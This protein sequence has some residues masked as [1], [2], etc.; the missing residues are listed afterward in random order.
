MMRDLKNIE[1]SKFA[2]KREKIQ[3][4]GKDRD[5]VRVFS[6]CGTIALSVSVIMLLS[7]VVWGAPRLKERVFDSR[8]FKLGGID[9]IGVVKADRNEVR[10]AIGVRAGSSVLETDLGAIRDR[11]EDVGWVKDVEVM[12]ELPSKLIVRVV[13]HDPVG[14]IVKED[15]PLFVDS[16][17]ETA[18][19]ETDYS[20]Y[21]RFVG[22]STSDEITSGAGLLG[23]IMESGIMRIGSVKSLEYDSVMGYTV[24]SRGG[25]ELR[26]GHPPFE[27]KVERLAIILLDATARG[28]IEYIYLDIEDRIIVKN[29]VN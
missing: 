27:G 25:V 24:R 6:T 8:Y 2:A 17:G 28:P 11:V 3:R 9:V 18:N 12:R 15:G 16:D 14:V 20:G 13:E 22:M 19:I 26:F 1:R 4:G 10:R 7:L 29:E 5:G 23:L 21:P